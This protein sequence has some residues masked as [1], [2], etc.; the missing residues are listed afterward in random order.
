MVRTQQ[1][2][3][4]DLQGEDQNHQ[5]HGTISTELV[6]RRMWVIAPPAFQRPH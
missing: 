6:Q 1:D 4:E 2:D 3:N 5:E